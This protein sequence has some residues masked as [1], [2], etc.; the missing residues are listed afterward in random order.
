MGLFGI[1]RFAR[2]NNWHPYI[3]KSEQ[4]ETTNNINT[5]H[6]AKK[7]RPNQE[8]KY[9]Y[10]KKKVNEQLYKIHLECAKQR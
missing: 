9:R 3:S 2:V 7:Y 8:L 6:A 10:M 4:K 5:K 1:I